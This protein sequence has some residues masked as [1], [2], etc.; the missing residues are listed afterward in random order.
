MEPRIQLCYIYLQ[1]CQSNSNACNY[2]KREIYYAMQHIEGADIASKAYLDRLVDHTD[3]GEVIAL[4]EG[5][6]MTKIF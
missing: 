5:A 2:G 4:E 3:L 1:L 6:A